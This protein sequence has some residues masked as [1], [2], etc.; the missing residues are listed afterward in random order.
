MNLSSLI[1]KISTDWSDIID[2]Y[3]MS[4]IEFGLNNET[5]EIYPSANL[6]FNCFD[7]F[8]VSETKVVILG[9]DPYI[10][11]GQAM[12]LSFSVPVNMKVPPSLLNIYKEISSDLNVEIDKSNGDLSEW[13]SKGVLLLNAALTVAA[14]KS[15]THMKLWADFTDYIIS[16]ISSNVTGVVFILWGNFARSKKKLVCERK[17]CVLEA[18]HPSPLSANRGGFFGCKHFS[19]CNELLGE[20]IF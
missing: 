11:A 3:D 2:K 1:N 5:S 15:G 17:H 13:A 18:S 10:K 6:I 4:D 14:G 20:K 12:G 8:N 9:Q 16:Y 19:K 7:F